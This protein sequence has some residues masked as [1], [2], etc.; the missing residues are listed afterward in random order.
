MT[1][2][3]SQHSSHPSA[4]SAAS[5]RSSKAQD[6]TSNASGGIKAPNSNSEPATT[7][8]KLARLSLTSSRRHDSLL[9]LR[10]SLA[11]ESAQLREADLSATTIQVDSPLAAVASRR[12][13][14]APPRRS[15]IV[16]AAPTLPTLPSE[17]LLTRRATTKV[18]T[19]SRRPKA[20]SGSGASVTSA[21]F[22]ALS[23]SGEPTTAVNTTSA[24]ASPERPRA[25]GVNGNIGAKGSGSR[26]FSRASVAAIAGLQ[27]Q[28]DRDRE[29]TAAAAARRRTTSASSALESEVAR[30]VRRAAGYESERVVERTD[31]VHA[32]V[33]RA[34][35]D[36]NRDWEREQEGG[37][38]ERRSTMTGIFSRA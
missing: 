12:L 31:A 24:Q 32:R 30:Q 23:V 25:S 10:D 20:S 28:M 2:F 1:S 16:S 18:T 29:N 38:R 14:D 4:P 27:Q 15:N 21:I 36:S 3:T 7:A 26:T 17:S 35:L 19:I 34:S 33:G 8:R 13:N 5:S 22:P 11:R 37:A 6:N 9:S